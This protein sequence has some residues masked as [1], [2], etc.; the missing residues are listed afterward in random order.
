MLLTRHLKPHHVTLSQRQ[1]GR[2]NVPLFLNTQENDNF[3]CNILIYLK[4]EIAGYYFLIRETST[5]AT[6]KR[7]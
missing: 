4:N 2:V 7:P 5:L 3:K 6:F 1:N